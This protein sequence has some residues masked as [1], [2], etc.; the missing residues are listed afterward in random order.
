MGDT[1]T[2][3]DALQG[4]RTVPS[5]IADFGSRD[6][7]VRAEAREQLAQHGSDAVAALT[8]ALEH[9]ATSVRWEAAKTLTMMSDSAATD[10]LIRALNDQDRPVRWLAAKGLIAIGPRCVPTLLHTL[11]AHGDNSYIL[12]GAHHVLKELCDDTTRPVVAALEGSL[13]SL[14]APIAAYH[15]IDKL[16]R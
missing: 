10:A 16:G 2:D 11:V 14:E 5:L 6:A 15:A 9:P 12:E 7:R 4:K 13:P 1:Q 8:Q 3:A